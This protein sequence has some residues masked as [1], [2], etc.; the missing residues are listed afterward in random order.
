M[1]AP[2]L[3]AGIS[4]MLPVIGKFQMYLWKWSILWTSLY[5]AC[6]LM[7]FLLVCNYLDLPI[8]AEMGKIC[9]KILWRKN[10]L[11]N[12]NSQHFSNVGTSTKHRHTWLY[13]LEVYL[14]RELALQILDRKCAD[15]KYLQ[16]THLYTG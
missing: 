13:L 16:Y 12:V 14:K 10:K 8:M 6:A 4:W 11:F 9:L 15:I 7:P 1:L 2:L 3:L 5:H